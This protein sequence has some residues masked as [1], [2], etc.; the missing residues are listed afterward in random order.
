A[1]VDAAE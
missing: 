1:I